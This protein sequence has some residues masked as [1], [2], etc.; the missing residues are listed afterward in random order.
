MQEHKEGTVPQTDIEY[1]LCAISEYQH[2]F[3]NLI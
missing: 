3:E 1:V 2:F